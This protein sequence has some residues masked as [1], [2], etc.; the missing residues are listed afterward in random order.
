MRIKQGK[1]VASTVGG[2]AGIAECEQAR[3]KLLSYQ[4]ST[5]NITNEVSYPQRFILGQVNDGDAV[6]EL[7]SFLQF[8]SLVSLVGEVTATLA[9]EGSLYF[10]LM[11]RISISEGQKSLVFI[12]VAYPTQFVW[13]IT[14]LVFFLAANL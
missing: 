8:P 13:K 10:M 7:L 4:N 6:S 1:G 12:E 2:M 11:N 3:R 14:V 9:R 5:S